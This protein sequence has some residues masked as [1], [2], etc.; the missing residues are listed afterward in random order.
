M[1][2][3]DLAPNEGA[4]KNRKRVG[5]GIAAGQGKTGWQHNT[6]ADTLDNPEY[7]HG[8]EVPSYATQC[9]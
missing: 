6:T 9:R 5:R 3:H 7:D 2:L 8:T 1:K 4:K